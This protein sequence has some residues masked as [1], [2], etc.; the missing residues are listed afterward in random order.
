V[1]F[2]DILGKLGSQM[3]VRILHWFGSRFGVPFGSLLES[4]LGTLGPLGHPLGSLWA[5]FGSFGCLFQHFSL[6][7][8][9]FGHSG[10]PFCPFVSPLGAFGMI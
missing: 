6:L 8:G 5:A 10:V 2:G 9:A 1:C 3:W 4:F 7:L